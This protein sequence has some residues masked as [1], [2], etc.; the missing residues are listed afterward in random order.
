MKCINKLAILM[1]AT[2]I[3]LATFA[4][5]A[6]AQLTATEFGFPS[7][8]QSGSTTAFTKDLVTAQD[9]E[10]VNI[11]FGSAGLGCGL[12]FPSI[13]QTVDKS[14]YAEH[15]DFSHTE[16]TAAFNYPFASVGTVGGCGLTGFGGLA[17]LGGLGGL[18]GL[19]LPAGLC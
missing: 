14:Y 2:A 4:M 15:T 1:A 10:S 5:S 17:G 16:E 18:A 19:G 7:V 13:S 3:V 9:L 8:F 12:G 6:G 11:D